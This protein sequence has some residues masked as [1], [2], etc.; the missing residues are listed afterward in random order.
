M[1]LCE[2]GPGGR[3]VLFRD[4]QQVVVAHRLNEVLPALAR[5]ETARQAGKWVAGW[6]GYEAGY[7]FEERLHPLAPSTQG[8][9]L[10]LGIHD[11]PC[12]AG[13]EFAQDHKRLRG[14]A[15]K[16]AAS[17][18]RNKAAGPRCIGCESG[19]AVTGL[20]DGPP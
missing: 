8:P 3:A 19:F 13:T 1:I 7:A 17:A 20:A 11:A 15:R 10:A 4:A 2:F 6:I 9:L 18:R 14:L 5:A 16:G 12:P